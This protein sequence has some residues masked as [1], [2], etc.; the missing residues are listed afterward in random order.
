MSFLNAFPIKTMFE[1]TH[2]KQEAVREAGNSECDIQEGPPPP[3]PMRW[4]VTRCFVTLDGIQAKYLCALT[5]NAPLAHPMR[6]ARPLFG[7]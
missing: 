2:L 3:P 7:T 1:L 5:S 6:A 4:D